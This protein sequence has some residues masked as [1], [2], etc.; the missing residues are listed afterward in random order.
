MTRI[1][2]IFRTLHT[3][4]KYE[5]YTRVQTQWLSFY[6]HSA[7][8]Q[9]HCGFLAFSCPSS[10]RNYCYK[11]H[12][13]VWNTSEWVWEFCN[14][15]WIAQEQTRFSIGRLEQITGLSSVFQSRFRS[16]ALGCSWVSEAFNSREYNLV[17]HPVLPQK[18]HLSLPTPPNSTV[19]L[20]GK[21]THA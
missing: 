14:L 9:L 11:L 3:N 7:H 15:I 10:E 5:G 4:L 21:R 1:I 17:T 6:C 20:R 16:Q 19:Q 12:V 2:L 13:S 18:L 8:R